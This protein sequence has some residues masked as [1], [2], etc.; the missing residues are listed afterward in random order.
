MISSQSD[1]IFKICIFGDGGVGKTALVR[2]YL[3]GLFDESTSMT[4]GL[5]CYSKKF[6]IKDLN[7]T[8]QIWDFAG[9]ARFR[10]LLPS[11]ITGSSGGIFMFDITRYTSFNNFPDWLNIFKQIYKIKDD[12]SKYP[13]IIVG[14]K[15]DLNDTR[16]VPPED[17]ENIVENESLYKYMECSAKNGDN[18]ENIFI[19]ITKYMLKIAQI[20]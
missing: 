17:A 20:I 9:E 4:I 19:E 18:V 7:I 3:S 8:L 10:F 1:A 16:S 6:K 11:Y 2:R 13:I 12:V 14:G 5:D 15:S